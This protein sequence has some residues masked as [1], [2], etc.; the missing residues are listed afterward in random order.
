VQCR[1]TTYRIAGKSELPK[2]SN[3]MK[4]T[5]GNKVLDLLLLHGSGLSAPELLA[6]LR[7][8]VSQP[9]LWRTLDTL[10]AHGAL[11]REGRARATRYHA[12]A[13]TDLAVLRSRRMHE[14][15]AKRLLREP[16]LRVRALERLAKL[17]AV[18]PHGR[19]YH[20]RWHE[21]LQGPLVEAVRVMTE[22]SEMADV[23]RKES[24]F[25]AFISPAERQ[26][27]FDSTRAG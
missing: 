26:R 6:K 2:R 22:S 24:P 4:M 7:P 13:R 21:L 25:S 14:C 10:R 17:R 23:L 5:L 8:R 18:N 20:D 11:I 3:L 12:R 15:V 1:V 27:I 19:R 16:A 9:T